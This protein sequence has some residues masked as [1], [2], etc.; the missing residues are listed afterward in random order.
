VRLLRTEN[1]NYVFRL[2]AGE[3]ELLAVVL[4]LY[5]VIP[6]AHQSISNS[7]GIAN[8]A[9]QRLL[10]EAL[11]EQR[12]ENKK[13]VSSF[14]ADPQRFQETEAGARLTITP[15]EV[16]WMLQVLNDVHVG[17]WILAGSPGEDS[18]PVIPTDKNARH[19]GAMEL[20][21]WFQHDL[22]VALNRPPEVK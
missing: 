20:A 8:K 14:L 22:L 18:P 6:P 3:K 7:T 12:S 11:A 5:P 16:E 9:N 19:I 2:G 17:S 4:S 15:A 1:G 10:D 21:R 13:L